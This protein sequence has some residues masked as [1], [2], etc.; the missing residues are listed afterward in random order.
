[1]F[2]N[3]G[4]KP[5]GSEALNA[6]VALLNISL[7]PGSHTISAVYNGDASDQG[8]ASPALVLVVGSPPIKAINHIVIMLQE[9]RSFDHYFGGLNDYRVTQGLPPD[10]DIATKT[11]SN[12]NFDN[13]QQISFYKLNTV[14]TE[15]PTSDW[16]ESH[17]AY[18]RAHPEAGPGVNDGFVYTG[19]TYAREEG[20]V[21]TEGRRV[22]GYYTEKELP[23]YYFMATA[24]ATSDRFFSPILSRTSPN[25][26]YLMA[27][28]SAGYAHT[29]HVQLTA[30]TIFE[31]LEDAGISWKIYTTDPGATYL[32]QFLFGDSHQDKIQGVAE[33]LNDLNNG[34]LPQVSLIEAGYESGLDEHPDASIQ[35]GAAYTASL[36]NA[37]MKS[38]AWKDGVFLFSYDEGGG[39]YDHVPPPP[40]VQPD[41]IP[42]IDL[43]PEDVQG[44][45][46]H[47]GFRVPMIVISPFTKKGYVSHTVSDYTAFLKLIETRFGLPALTK[48]DASQPDMLEFF[49]FGHP[50]WSTPPSPPPQRTDGLCYT[51]T[52]P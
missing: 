44:D 52:L 11:S 20:E 2:F 16:N 27:A 10:L 45:F 39:Y 42:P 31:E 26:M 18:N 34:T 50:S 47:Y 3:D 5:L 17:V 24:F 23:Y 38:S 43:A 29:L 36:I 8:S 28:T 6:G 40:A 25:R 32:N 15:A 41:G 9:N 19:A 22:M 46:D 13:T 49:D 12:P 14:C 51:N 21:D 35:T 37:F 7:D 1:V 30:K 48:R 4:P 33:Y